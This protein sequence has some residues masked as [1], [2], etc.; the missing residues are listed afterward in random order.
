MTNVTQPNHTLHS[1]LVVRKIMPNGKGGY[2]I[3]SYGEGN[4]IK[5]LG[6]IAREG[7]NREWSINSQAIIQ[8]AKN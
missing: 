6:P 8:K 3:M 7:A 1:G 2:K 5:Q 4:A